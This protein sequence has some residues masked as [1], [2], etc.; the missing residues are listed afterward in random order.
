MLERA[1][2]DGYLGTCAPLR[3]C[4]L[5]NITGKPKVPMLLVACSEDGSTP[6]ENMRLTHRLF[7]NSSFEII[8]GAG[9]L[10]CVEQPAKTANLILRFM[11]D[12]AFG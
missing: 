1:T 11:K 10:P 5:S 2:L 9:H 4:D 12:H 8:D 7:T 3:D 6:L